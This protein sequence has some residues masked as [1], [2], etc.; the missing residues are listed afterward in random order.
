MGLL[1]RRRL[2]QFASAEQYPVYVYDARPDDILWST[3]AEFLK[4]KTNIK[5]DGR[6]LRQECFDKFLEGTFRNPTRTDVQTRLNDYAKLSDGRGIERNVCKSHW[7]ERKRNRK[8]A[9]QAVI[10]AQRRAK[11]YG[12]NTEQTWEALREICIQYSGDS[13]AFA[14][15]MGEADEAACYDAKM[16][17]SRDT[18]PRTASQP[19]SCTNKMQ[20]GRSAIKV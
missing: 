19:S 9:N 1:Q 5:R 20:V 17:S 6:K 13:R 14:R 12:L 4:G 16:L 8:T 3:E 10:E 2:V 15:R 7:E 11:E 18:A